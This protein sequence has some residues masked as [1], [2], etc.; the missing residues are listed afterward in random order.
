MMIEIKYP[1]MPPETKAHLEELELIV[2][3]IHAQAVFD[4]QRAIEPYIN[5]IADIRALYPPSIRIP[6][7][8]ARKLF[9]GEENADK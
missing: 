1:D 5:A 3:K 6:D 9:L 2:K 7:D 8:M 4:Y